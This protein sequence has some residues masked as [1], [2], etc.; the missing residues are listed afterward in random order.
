MWLHQLQIY[1]HTNLHIVSVLRNYMPL[2]FLENYLSRRLDCGTTIKH[3]FLGCRLRL[4]HVISRITVSNWG[5]VQ[6]YP[7]LNNIRVVVVNTLGFLGL[8]SR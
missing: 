5:L 4:S 6:F 8:L 2:I 7:T 3:I 1:V